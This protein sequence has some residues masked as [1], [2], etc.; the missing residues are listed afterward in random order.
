MMTARDWGER[1]VQ[2]GRRFAIPPFVR[3]SSRASISIRLIVLS[4]LLL[5]ALVATN[6]Y[7]I[8]ELT[9]NSNSVAATTALFE[10]LEAANAASNAFGRIRYWMTDLAVSLLTLSE[11]NGREARAELDGHLDRLSASYPEFVAAV[12]RET[13]AYMAKALQAADAYT[14]GHRVIGNTLL[15]QAREHS[16]AVDAQL[17]GLVGRLDQL[18]VSSRDAALSGAVAAARTSIFV[19]TAAVVIGALLTFWILRSIVAPLRALIAAVNG[20]IDGR[21]DVPIPPAGRDEIGQMTHALALL[22]SSLVERRRLEEEAERQRRTIETAIETISDGFVLYDSDDRVVMANGKYRSIYPGLADLVTPGRRFQEVAAAVVKR[23]LAA[24]EGL[25]KEARL[26]RRLNRHRNPQGSFEERYAD[27]AWVRIS[28]RKTPDGGTVAVYSDITELKERQKELERAKSQAESASQAKSQFL[29][30]MSHELRTPLNAIL[31]Y[32][33]MLLEEVRELE[34]DELAPDLEKIGAAGRH[35]LSLINDILD[36][37][38]IEA[39]KMDVFVEQFAVADMLA[40]VEATVAPLIARNGNVLD[41]KIAGALAEMRS[42]QTKLRQILF[43]LLSNAAKFT[44]GGRIELYARRETKPEGDW[45]EFR[46]ADTGIGMTSE[47]LSRLFQ[48]FSQADASTTRSYGGTG[49]GLAITKH[50]C[51]LLGGEVSVE[52]RFGEGSTFTVRA[53]A[54]CSHTI[55]QAIAPQKATVQATILLIDDERTLHDLLDRELADQGYRIVHAYSGEEGLRRAREA[56]PDAIVLDIIMPGLDGWS[57]LQKLKEDAELREIPVILATILGDRDMGFSLGAADY[58]TKPIDPDRLTQV[59]RRHCAA[60]R[61]DVLVVDDDVSSRELLRRALEKEGWRVREAADGRE[62]LERLSQAQPGLVLLDLMM[63]GMDGFQMLEAMR[64]Q[65]AYE[66]I[67]VVVVTAKDLRREEVDWLNAHAEEVF[68]KG[69]FGRR[70]LVAI[71]QKLLAARAA[72]QA[73]AGT[74]P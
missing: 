5:A 17:A 38:K 61:G 25:S 28:E 24:P 4:A 19:V 14:D 20:V 33:E 30:S 6:A 13:D 57:V 27:G 11:R 22:R 32:S 40:E 51:R 60:A 43:N 41:V 42:D 55:E 59:L 74:G 47:Q 50:F 70:K 48:A 66:A 15:A 52:S 2:N 31:G 10:Q 39:G 64:R 12:Q 73:A 35:L 65:E 67:P 72:G 46:I 37:S 71:V 54:I 26:E 21:L 23:N 8:R 16:A 18:A 3:G 68:R 9:R 53:P 56:R 34:A 63:P 62:G 45:L 1:A 49:L 69:A 29:A 7:L 58:L 44:S 36:L